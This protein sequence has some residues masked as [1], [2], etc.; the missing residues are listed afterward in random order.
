MITA[1]EAKRISYHSK[2]YYDIVESK[3]RTAAENGEVMCVIKPEDLPI[4]TM[5]ILYEIS[6]FLDEFG[7]RTDVMYTGKDTSVLLIGW[8]PSWTNHTSYVGESDSEEY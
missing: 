6:N 5:G 1:L 4:K 8:L 3:I 2:P 7:Y